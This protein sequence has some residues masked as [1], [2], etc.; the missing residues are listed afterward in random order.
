MENSNKFYFPFGQQLTKV[1]QKDK[2]PKKAFVLGVY[3]SAVHAQWKDK[4]G[5]QK[6]AAL[7][8]ASEPEIFWRG[9]EEEGKKIISKI[10]IP[11]EVGKLEFSR[12]NG[13]SGQALDKLYLEPLGLSRKD[14]WLS[15]LLPEARI[16]PSQYEAIKR[17]YLPIAKDFGLPEVTVPKFRASELDLV[18][19]RE[20]ILNELENSKAETLILLGD[21]PIKKFLKFYGDK[22]LSNL[23]AFSNEQTPYGT[24]HELKINGRHYNVIPL[25]HPRQAARLGRSSAEWGMAHDNWIKNMRK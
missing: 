19:R 25:C 12:L 2:S 13:P 6:V 21:L 15:D 11:E 18:A 8:V 17:E 9:D 4:N 7:A 22:S 23:S 3:A 16:N 10:K 5:K 14:T 20:E 1:E 24:P